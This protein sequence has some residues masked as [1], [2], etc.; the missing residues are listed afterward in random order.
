MASAAP[1]RISRPSRLTPLMRLLAVKGMKRAPRVLMSRSRM[2]YSFFARTTMLLPSGVSSARDASCAASA[3]CCAVVPSTGRNS[4]ASRLPKVMV[5]VLS[6][7][8]TSTS[9]AAS[10]AL[11]DMAMTFAWIMRSMPAMPMA[12][13]R[14]PMVV[15]MRQM[16]R[17]TITVMVTGDPCP[18]ART[19]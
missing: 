2:P 4:V 14:P 7:R 1:L 16:S 15:G 3:S 9:P 12:E 11:P 8:R 6:S 18:V 19:L 10:T 17:A 13:S 5:P